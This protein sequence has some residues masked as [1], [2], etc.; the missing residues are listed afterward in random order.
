M[1]PLEASIGWVLRHR[2]EYPD[3]R[4]TWLERNFCVE[5]ECSRIRRSSRFERMR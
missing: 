5:F 2:R 4:I 3:H 1:T